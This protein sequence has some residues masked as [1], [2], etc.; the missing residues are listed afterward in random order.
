M[1]VILK[2]YIADKTDLGARAMKNLGDIMQMTGRDVDCEIIDLHERPE[3]AS[4]AH[5]LATP[6]LIKMAPEPIRKVIGDL[7]NPA[8]TLAHL[9]L[10]PEPDQD[11]LT[12]KGL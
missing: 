3:I 2:L 11:K 4:E 6:A 1:T 9:G 12:R 5:I 7:S 10:K 8:K